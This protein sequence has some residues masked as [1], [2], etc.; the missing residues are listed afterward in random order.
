MTSG[1][2][3]A[4]VSALADLKEA[5]RMLA[6]TA[7]AAARNAYAPYS[8]FAVGAAVRTRSGNLY[9]GANQENAAYGVTMCAEV[10]A[11]TAASSA[12]DF[13]VEAIA[14]AGSKFIE[15]LGDDLVVTPCGRCRQ[16]ICEAAQISQVDVRVMSCNGDLSRILD[17]RI[18][19]LLPHAFGPENLGLDKKWPSMRSKLHAVMDALIWGRANTR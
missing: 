5:D 4:R 10:A 3:E 6:K 8:G 15:P 7:Q 11:L 1:V 9:T 2:L 16:L 13:D 18:S 19:E 17:S 12:G 14:V